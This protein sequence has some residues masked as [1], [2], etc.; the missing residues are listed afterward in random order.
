MHSQ[1]PSVYYDI[2]TGIT[3][4]A[5][6]IQAFVLLAMFVVL[7]RLMA[8]V[9][10]I[11]EQ[12]QPHIPPIV[13]TTRNVVEESAPKV[14]LALD[15]LVEVVHRLH[16][17]VERFSATMDEVLKKANAQANRVDEMVTAGIDSATYASQAVQHAIA[18]PVRQ[19]SAVFAGLKAGFD[20]LRGRNHS[21]RPPEDEYCE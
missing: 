2:F 11:I 18:V 1:L 8:R 17:D 20:V 5:V 4:V 13:A 12:V 19:A 14:K 21:H 6:L 10:P 15:D 3:A 7:R 16:T 9:E